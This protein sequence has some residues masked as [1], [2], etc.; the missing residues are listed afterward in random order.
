MP[1]VAA[2]QMCS[3]HIVDDN[4]AA[5]QQLIQEAANQDAKLVVLPEMFAIMGEKA[6]DKVLVK[7]EFGKGK[8]QDFLAEQA[9]KNKIWLVGGTIPISCDEENKA[10]ATCLVYNDK[11]ELAARYDKTHLFDVTVSQTESYKESATTQAGDKIVVIPTPFGKLGLS[12][13]YDIRFPELYRALFNAGAEIIAI[14]AAFTVMTGE[15]HWELLARARAVENFCYVIGACQ[16]GTHNNG[17]KTYGHSL[18]IEPWGNVAASLS[19]GTGVITS[20]IDLEKLY[21]IRK[22]VP[23]AEHRRI[24]L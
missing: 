11:G 2:I 20:N 8:I 16:W 17:R 1:I 15:A 21:A 9:R 5:A 18:I 19:E 24:S 13:C 4:L 3:S 12:V 7:E 22:D 23:V 6:S 10:R 14:P